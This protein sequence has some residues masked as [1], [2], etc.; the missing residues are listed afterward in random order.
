[1][2]LT[3]TEEWFLRRVALEGDVDVAAGLPAR[4][5]SLDEEHPDA[6]PDESHLSL[7]PHAPLTRHAPARRL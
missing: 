6:T 4:H 1:M 5:P 7:G 2:K 3:L